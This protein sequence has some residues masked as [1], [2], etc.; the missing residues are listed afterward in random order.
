MPT[1][2]TTQKIAILNY[3]KSVYTH[4]TAETVYQVVKKQLPAITLATVYRNLNQMAEQGEISRLEINKKYHYDAEMDEHQHCVCSKCS[5]IFDVHQDKFANES[6]K[7]IKQPGFK[8]SAVEI[9][10]LGV[11]TSCAN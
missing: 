3:L 4:P 5:K 7:E 10:F 8:I 1:R 11:C 6:I 9:V 2:N